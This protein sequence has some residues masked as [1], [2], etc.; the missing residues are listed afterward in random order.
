MNDSTS[1]EIIQVINLKKKYSKGKK[2]VH[3]LNDVTFGIQKGEIFALLGPNGAGKTTLVKILLNFIRPDSG[4]AKIMGI[5]VDEAR[6]RKKLGYVPEELT[7]PD[8]PNA[9]KFLEFLGGL[10]GVE[11]P[12]LRSDINVLL[13][14][15]DLENIKYSIKKYSKGMKRRLS[16]AQALLHKPQLLILDEPTD[17]LDPIERTRVLHLLKEYRDAGG[18]ILICSHILS[19]VEALCNRYAIIKQGKILHIGTNQE[20]ISDGYRII[21]KEIQFEELK[22]KLSFDGLI[23]KHDDAFAFIVKKE[24]DLPHVLFQLEQLNIPVEKIEQNRLTLND[25]FLK[26]VNE[27]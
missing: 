24:K 20:F 4:K 6:A 8:F 25:L 7:M 1:K 21:I 9:K 11:I 12:L 5:S 26:Y 16:L 13:K 14:Q 3:A 18:T 23:E 22:A 19:D 10:S 17:G 27:G 15:A 2:I